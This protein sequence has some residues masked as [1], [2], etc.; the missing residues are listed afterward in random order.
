ME[1]FA[2]STYAIEVYIVR[3]SPLLAF[4]LGS[5]L[6]VGCSAAPVKLKYVQY[7]DG[8]S[9]EGHGDYS[10]LTKFSL[11]K[12]ILL[13]RHA[14]TG[15]AALMT[16]VPAE[17]SGPRTHF[18]VQQ[19]TTASGNHLLTVTKLDNSNLVHRLTSDAPLQPDLQYKDAASSGVPTAV[20]ASVDLPDSKKPGA[21]LSLPLA[22]DT[23]RLLDQAFRG[24]TTMWAVAENSN[25]KIAFEIA[26]DAVPTDAI[27]TRQLD[28]G[29][30][31]GL[32]FYS[33][34][35]TAT[36]TF[37][38]APLTRQQF[39]VTVADPHF[40]QTIALAPQSSIT[41]H[42]GCGVDIHSSTAEAPQALYELNQAIAQAR[43]LN[44]AWQTLPGTDKTSAIAEANASNKAAQKTAKAAAATAAAATAAAE[45]KKRDDALRN[46]EVQL[47]KQNPP[48]QTFAF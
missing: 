32:Y 2:H 43:S 35:R 26:F 38:T 28:L 30:A 9:E 5:P 24:P 11:A 6:L 41:S 44:T 17:A 14:E 20:A 21:A 47:P 39:T 10:G 27:E 37:L 40:V 18:G 23:G 42:S 16:S 7:E 4:V 46:A 8:R 12:S 33:A 48:R 19:D 3:I 29:K 45:Q 25:R 36:V 13:V 31:S 34:C 22:I 1:A 15:S